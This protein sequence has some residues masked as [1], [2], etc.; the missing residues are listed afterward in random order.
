MNAPTHH[1]MAQ[2]K[3]ELVLKSSD[4]DYVATSCYHGDIDQYVGGHLEFCPF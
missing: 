4:I 3:G 1:K 2:M